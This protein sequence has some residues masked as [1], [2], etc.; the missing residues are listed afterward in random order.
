MDEGIYL[1]FTSFIYDY[2]RMLKTV[3]LYFFNNYKK[4]V[5][6]MDNFICVM[7]IV[8]YSL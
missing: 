6:Y 2:K 4:F 1:F 5:P 7:I 8:H 3:E